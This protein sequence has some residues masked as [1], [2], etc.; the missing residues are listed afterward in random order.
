M[1]I[2]FL[3]LYIT[4]DVDNKFYNSQEIGLARAICKSNTEYRVD[5]VLLSKRVTSKQRY[6][7][8]EKICIYTLPA[9]GFGHHGFLD[10][11]ILQELQADYVHL[12]AD[13]MIYAPNVIKYCKQN[14]IGCHLYIGTLFSDSDKWYKQAISRLLMM[15]NI[16]AYRKV[17]VYTK[18][19][20]ALEQCKNYGIN[21]KLA[22]V[23]LPE[24]AMIISD[25][26]IEDIR[27]E[28][29]L[30][31]DKKILLFVGRLEAYK[32]P[33]DSVELLNRL[34][35]D[36]HLCIVGKGELL[37]EVESRASQYKLNDR[38][39]LLSQVPNARMKDLFKACDYYINF[40]PDEIYGMAILEAM[41]HECL[42]LAIKAAGPEF[43]IE[44]GITG[45]ICNDVAEMAD[46]IAEISCLTD[47]FDT[48]KML[49]RARN[50]VLDKFTWEKTRECF[51]FDA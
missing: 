37:K 51:V 33:L 45:F 3:K 29:R 1:N 20:K 12:L 34:G 32:H 27:K 47:A 17:Q 10:L 46:R 31:G 6:V 23:G 43:L 19:P 36:Y 41:S 44:N 13:N 8:S 21:A 9:K 26:N 7:D 16:K 22:P 5:I 49:E 18:T 50:R 25:R 14:R 39:T 24:E 40:N 28:Y 11:S 35:E 4:E 38:V 42:V 2:V 15:R 48:T 30:P